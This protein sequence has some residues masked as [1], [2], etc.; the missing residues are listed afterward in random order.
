VSKVSSYAVL[1][2]SAFPKFYNRCTAIPTDIDGLR[3][4]RTREFTDVLLETLESKMLWDEYGIDDDV[5]VC[6]TSIHYYILFL[7]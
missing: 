7:L 2:C 6:K 5:L 1:K 4:R 3:G